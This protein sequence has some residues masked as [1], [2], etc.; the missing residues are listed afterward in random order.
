VSW[1]FRHHYLA[2]AAVVPAALVLSGA[3]HLAARLRAAAMFVAGFV[4][5]GAPTM[6]LN[7]LA[8]GTPVYTGYSRYF[9]GKYAMGWNDADFLG[10][11]DRWPLRR[12]IAEEPLAL[13]R[14]V[15]RNLGG[16]IIS[17]TVL[18]A[19]LLMGVGL[20]WGLGTREPV[21]RRAVWLCLTI[22]GLYL[23]VVVLPTVVTFRALWPVWV[24]ASWG[25]ALVAPDMMRWVKLQHGTAVAAVATA[26]LVVVT[27]YTSVFGEWIARHARYRENRE[28][29]DWL[30]G[31]GIVDPVDVLTNRFDLYPLFDPRLVTF[32]GYGGWLQLNPVF[33]RERPSPFNFVGTADSW[34]AFATRHGKRIIIVGREAKTEPLFQRTE[35][36]GD[37]ALCREFRTL[38]AFCRR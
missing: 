31:Q 11:Y 8:H 6:A 4:V 17:R 18:V 33:A 30:V 28:V 15:G 7:L 1:W 12:L 10:T 5:G 13:V 22:C 36:D 27:G 37:W 38:R 21:R 9:P 26:L 25:L 2:F 19:M 20:A 3:G 14:L 23:L 24:L 34:A 32:H 35:L 16:L 29:S